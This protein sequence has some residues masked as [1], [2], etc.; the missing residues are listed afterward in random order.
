MSKY[1][2]YSLKSGNHNS[3]CTEK[4]LTE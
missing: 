4:G 3:H 1:R 2:C